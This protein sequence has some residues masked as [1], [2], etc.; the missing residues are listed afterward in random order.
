MNDK[1]EQAEVML[2]NLLALQHP[3]ESTFIV[4]HDDV[5]VTLRTAVELLI[6][7]QDR[8]IGSRHID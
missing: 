2:S 3:T 4:G 7:E 8:R 5:V 6:E 1:I